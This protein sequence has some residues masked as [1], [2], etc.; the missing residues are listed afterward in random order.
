MVYIGFWGKI[1]GGI[2]KAY[3]GVK[4][5]AKRVGS[6][7]KKAYQTVAHRRFRDW[8]SGKF[9][10]GGLVAA[11][12]VV[13]FVGFAFYYGVDTKSTPEQVIDLILPTP[14][15]TLQTGQQTSPTV[16]PAQGSTPT[17]GG[18]GTPIPGGGGTP[19][20]IVTPVTPPAQDTI[21]PIF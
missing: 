5:A 20:P 1:W 15:P 4:K 8:A 18:G 16:G 14:T 13:S 7:F 19:T 10:L 11:A 3:N 21:P 2:K 6:A 17:P 9:I 12:I